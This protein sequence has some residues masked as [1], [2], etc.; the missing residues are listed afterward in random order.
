VGGQRV[1]GH[2]GGAPGI[3]GQLDVY[4]DAGL[5]V[6]VLANYDP[7]AAQ[8]AAL[9]VRGLVGTTSAGTTGGPKGGGRA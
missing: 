3:S 1:V 5:T 9:F 4:P 7:P 8:R 6:A 2:N